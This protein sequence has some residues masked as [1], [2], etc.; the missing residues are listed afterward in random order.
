MSS[1]YVRVVYV[2]GC[3]GLKGVGAV[4]AGSVVDRVLGK[5]WAQMGDVW[6]RESC[7]PATIFIARGQFTMLGIIQVNK[8][9]KHIK[10]KVD[11]ES[12]LSVTIENRQVISNREQVIS[13]REQTAY[14]LLETGAPSS[15][16]IY[17]GPDEVCPLQSRTQSS[18]PLFHQ[19]TY[20]HL[21]LS[22]EI[23]SPPFP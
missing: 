15:P 23:A 6:V 21:N 13:H 7:G 3:H 2:D 1:F 12:N 16:Q 20:S 18:R 4:A 5:P 11:S 14:Q 10:L 17:Q 19:T 22:T 8:S 9:T